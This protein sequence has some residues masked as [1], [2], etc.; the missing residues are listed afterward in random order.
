MSHSR[1]DEKSEVEAV[2]AQN[3][4]EVDEFR[5]EEMEYETQYF[6]F[7]PKSFIDSLYNSVFMT[8]NDQLDKMKN[9]IT[10]NHLGV[11]SDEELEE[12]ILNI[13]TRM[14][15][16]L[17]FRFV[18]FEK[19]AFANVFAIPPY[20]C[21]PEDEVQ[22]DERVLSVKKNELDNEVRELEQR[23]ARIR[24]LNDHMDKELEMIKIVRE[25][26]T[27]AIEQLKYTLETVKEMSEHRR[28]KEGD[29]KK[30][31]ELLKNNCHVGDEEDSM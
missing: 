11:L 1:E 4:N 13:Q 9:E 16:V 24:F 21:L 31:L 20:V 7:G 23:T 8:L 10:K 29:V 15:Q 19:F 18:R 12:A 27:E 26:Q 28:E 5:P 6:R 30:L 17:N 22:T 25:E 3:E 2:N 14:I